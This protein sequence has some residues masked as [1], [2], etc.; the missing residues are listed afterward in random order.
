MTAHDQRSRRIPLTHGKW[1][2]VDADDY[3][4][5]SCFKW[6]AVRIRNTWYAHTYV[7]GAR[8]FMHRFLMGAVPG[9]RVDH[10]DGDGLNNTHVNLR[11]ITN[12]MNQAN[13]HRVWSRSGYKGVSFDAS[14]KPPR[15]WRALITVDGKMRFLGAFATPE[16]AARTYDTAARELFGEFACTNEELGLLPESGVH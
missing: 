8:E 1:A 15:Q 9:D 5:L 12:S 16:E 6:R 11:R 13:K 10:R 7:E 4:L 3:E 14:R 2:L